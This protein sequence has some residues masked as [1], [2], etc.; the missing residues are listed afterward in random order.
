MKIYKIIISVTTN[1]PDIPDWG[2]GKGVL[3]TQEAV[4]KDDITDLQLAMSLNDLADNLIKD[5]ITIKFEEIDEQS[6]RI[7]RNN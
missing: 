4:Y 6:T 7:I 1:N 5:T 2:L 3:T